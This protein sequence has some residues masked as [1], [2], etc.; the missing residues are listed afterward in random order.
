M[1]KE[2]VKMTTTLPQ[3][4]S[5]DC[6]RPLGALEQFLSLIDQHRPG[7]FAVA[8]HIVGHAP[9]SAWREALDKL[10][11]R[12]PLLSVAIE[13]DDAGTPC[14]QT[15]ED[16]RIPLSVKSEPTVSSWKAEIAREIATPFDSRQ[17]PLARA[18]LIH[19]RGESV[20]IFTAHHS[21]ADGISSVYAIR[22][23]LRALSG[24]SL[25][26]LPVAPALEQLVHLSGRAAHDANGATQPGSPQNER[27]GVFRV[28]DD[29]MPHVETLSLTPE[30]TRTLTER[31]R[32]ERTTVHGALCSALV[33]AGR[34]S[35]RHWNDSPVR[36]MS[37][38]N[39]RR[40][41]GIGE[42]CGLFV[43][44]GIFPM[45]P[46]SIA[47]FWDAARFAKTA[48]VEQQSLDRVAT[49]LELLEQTVNAG[50]DVQGAAQAV[51]HGYP[52][53]LLLTNLGKL[54]IQLNYGSLGLKALWGPSVLVG[55]EGAQTVGVATTN[56]SLCL[57]HT[58]Y[59][60]IPSLLPRAADI[61][62]LVC[63]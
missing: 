22:D 41:L 33:L 5:I 20:F 26:P 19:G 44:A 46:R 36:V 53:E 6:A 3:L 43:Q 39:L 50:L 42:D 14:F 63:E 56:D 52:H 24:E 10:Q 7:H 59:T 62:E 16:V 18:V 4:V 1:F 23:V 8:A 34:N 25:E 57:I 17:A 55:L 37:P 40:D 11:E 28:I 12:H 54:P 29:S 32:K 2:Y 60:P 13:T 49:R 21:I 30:M 15:F 61:L 45:N 9:V 47:D 51:I 38:F 27:P 31:A 35:S 58:S 48:L